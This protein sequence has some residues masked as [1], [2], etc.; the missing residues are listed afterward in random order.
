MNVN[1]KDFQSEYVVELQEKLD[2]VRGI[3]AKQ[4]PAA[5]LLNAPTGSGKTLMATALIEGLLNGTET[6]PGEPDLTFV[7]LT[8]QPELN[9]QTYD[10]MILGSR[11]L[12]RKQLVIINA[13]LDQER[14][15]PGCIYFLNTQKLGVSTSFVQKSDKRTFT[16]WEMLQN[17][18]S[19]DPTKFIL[20]IDEAHRGTQGRE[21]V[22]AQT[23]MEKLIGGSKGEI[24]AVPVVVGISATP[25]HFVNLCSRLGRPL[26][27]VIVDP[28]RVRESGLIKD[29]VDLFHPDKVRPADVTM[30]VEAV[31]DWRQYR[32]EW[33][34]YGK[35]Q[36][37][38]MPDPVLVVQVEDARSGSKEL[39]RTDLD[40]VVG[41]LARELGADATEGW[42]AHAFQDESDFTAAGHTVRYLA[43]S[44]ID[45]DG[46]VRAVLFKTSLNTGWD[47]PR[48][49]VMA[50]F[51][52]ARDE[53][54][55]AQLVGRMVRAPLARRV[56][57]NEHLNT[58]ALY[59]P[60]YDSGTVD[61]VVARLTDESAPPT[62]VRK[63][64]Q[65]VQLH[66][67][68]DK[69]KC[70]EALA[71]I[72]SYT[73]PRVRPLKPVPRLAR[74]ASL[75]SETS[76]EA[77]PVKEYRQTL[78]AE[79]LAERKR[80]AKDKA[81]LKLVD[82]SGALEVLRRRV[83]YGIH[84]G[85]GSIGE[86]RSAVIAD[87]NVDDLFSE[88]GRQLGE[89]LHKEYLRSRVGEGAPPRQAKLELQALLAANGVRVKVDKAADALRLTWTGKHKAALVAMDEKTRM[90]FRDIEAAGPDPEITTMDPPGTIEAK[91]ATKTWKHHLYVDDAGMFPEDFAKSSWERRTVE[92]E[93][94]RKDLAGWLRNPD[95]QGWSFTIPRREAMRWIPF[96]PD[97]I[98]FATT[99]SGILPEIVDPHLLAAEDMPQRAVRLA[100]YAQDHG[101]VF[102]RIEMLVYESAT[103]EKGLRLDLMNEK[104]R[105][106]IANISTREQLKEIF[107]EQK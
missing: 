80:L 53:T 9:K 11:Q 43:P 68:E 19:A 25:D 1:L 81:F 101:D 22:D 60:F 30:L 44:T 65:V 39:S 27:Q 103:D 45:A 18:I 40:S 36:G 88:A 96:F 38:L 29:Y 78:V 105:A 2:I 79:L 95:R 91:K 37:E 70:F 54:N 90:A 12:A 94:K 16:L 56:I 23:I 98:F 50:S 87:E 93:L 57:S 8:D 92:A 49:E 59:L 21:A 13:G 52:T 20:V 71:R 106:R 5:T 100:Q 99:P 104:L 85:A 107:K 4:Q 6:S 61:K 47:C 48:A 33:D 89:G 14:L 102:R 97:F 64:D 75:L 72:P 24:E 74:L 86:A 83:A 62:G 31:R 35:E 41:T 7:W 77:A 73:I 66:R 10:K 55:I 42:I 51:R 15:D 76:L 28:E 58:V 67:A 82:E 69:A 84:D 63:G 3:A 46:R 34:A 26:F 32:T 17:T